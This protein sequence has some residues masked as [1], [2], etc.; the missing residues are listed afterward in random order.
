MLIEIKGYYQHDKHMIK[1]DDVEIVS[2]QSPRHGTDT[3]HREL[4]IQMKNS[5]LV[6][7]FL[8]YVERAEQEYNA[9]V[10]ALRFRDKQFIAEGV[11][12]D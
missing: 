5:T 11:T 9:I 4:V 12:Y 1:V 6:I 10:Q 7:E 2:L 8:K 3:N